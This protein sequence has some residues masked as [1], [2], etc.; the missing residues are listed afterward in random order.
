MVNFIFHS[1]APDT[2]VLR[3][4]KDMLMPY[5]LMLFGNVM[6]D[7]SK[8]FI[9]G[10]TYSYNYRG[11]NSAAGYILEPGI[12][13]RPLGIM[14]LGVSASYQRN[15][16]ELQYV[17]SRAVASSNA[18]TDPYFSTVAH[19]ILGTIDQSTL[20]LIFRV[21]LNLTPE[22]SIQYYGSPFISR[23]SYSEFKYA[24]DTKSG[25]YNNRFNIYNNQVLT[26]GIYYLDYDS[27]NTADYSIGNP[28]FNFHQFRSNLVAKWEYRLGSF[29]Y[30]VWS[31]EKTGTNGNSGAS[32]KES[33]KDL[34]KI[35][36][37]NIF[38]IK[39]SYWFSL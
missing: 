29:I 10:L 14:K 19:S 20:G 25:D 11:H 15:N 30:F 18:L 36:T 35:Y 31:A 23:G 34:K 28:D 1:G 13:V 24:T 27:N 9:A 37:N 6:S 39:L 4:G 26:D 21:D 38:L 22:F 33:Y 32:F 12:T 16:D 5:N 17:T 8:K 2:R 7:M 3:G